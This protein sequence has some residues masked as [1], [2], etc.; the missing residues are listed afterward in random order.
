MSTSHV[1]AQLLGAEA[2]MESEIFVDRDSARKRKLLRNARAVSRAQVVN[3]LSLNLVKFA[4]A[5]VLVI[6]ILFISSVMVKG[7]FAYKPGFL[8]FDGKGIGN[9][10]FNT[11]YLCLISLLISAPL[12]VGAGIYMSE[13]AKEGN[14]TDLIRLCMESLSSL[15]SVVIGLFGYLMFISLPQSRWNLLS[16]ALTL[17]IINLPLIARNTEDAARRVPK[18]VKAASY[19][20]GASK[21]QTVSRMIVP[22]ASQGIL[23]GIILAAGRVFGE[24]AALLYTAGMSSNIDWSSVYQ[25]GKS[26]SPFNLFRPGE[27]LALFIWAQRTEALG[28]DAGAKASFASAVLLL[29][30]LSFLIGARLLEKKVRGSQSHV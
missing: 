6:L 21:W 26:S 1:Y 2:G 29:L 8:A 20:L 16:A 7:L 5:F 22:A 4:V 25:V 23:T 10:I 18:A 15:P 9:Q 13:Y 3:A 27:T 14:L 30:V 12:G 24:A 11:C 28:A 19:A 17:S